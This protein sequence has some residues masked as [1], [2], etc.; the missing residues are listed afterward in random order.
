VEESRVANVWQWS[1]W[2]HELEVAGLSR[3]VLDQ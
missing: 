1:V 2:W 3:D